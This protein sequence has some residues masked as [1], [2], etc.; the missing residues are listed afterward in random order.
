MLTEDQKKLLRIAQADGAF[1]SYADADDSQVA[2]YPSVLANVS[3]LSDSEILP[4]L[5]QYKQQKV[6]E[7]N[8]QIESVA[9]PARDLLQAIEAL[10]I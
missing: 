7:L 10:N 1:N 5:T 9:A 2:I 4:I 3:N 6:E 8:L